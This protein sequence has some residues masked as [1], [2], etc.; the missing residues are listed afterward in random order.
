[1]ASPAP[2]RVVTLDDVE[3]AWSCTGMAQEDALRR[4]RTLLS[5]E[6]HLTSQG[7]QGKA[8]EVFDCLGTR[9]CLKALL[10]LNAAE[11]ER[12]NVRQAMAGKLLA[13]DGEWRCHLVVNGLAGFPALLC[14]GAYAGGPVILMEWVDGVPLSRFMTQNMFAAVD[15]A[16][17]GASVALSLAEARHRDPLFV[18][19]DVSPRNIMLRQDRLGL[20][21]QMAAHLF[22][23][24]VIDFG[25]SV[26]GGVRDGD[27]S[28]GLRVWR[29]ATPAYAPPEML[30]HQD[31]GQASERM[32]GAVD[33]YE[34]CS[35][36]AEMWSRSRPFS[37]DTQSLEAWREV[38][39]T[40][41][42]H[43]LNGTNAAE[44]R[45][46]SLLRQG[47]SP[48]PAAR[49]TIETAAREL[50]ACCDQKIP[51]LAARVASL[52]QA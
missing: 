20:G 3:L 38:K 49:P 4:C 42:P 52:R 13:F 10:P 33:V 47:L 45:L 43:V 9:L 44:R 16:S 8:I 14:R 22:D 5:L 31:G 27:A 7:G 15:C 17:L 35:V 39:L 32:S 24:C 29:N 1:M 6:P 21:Q 2:L 37:S 51:G 40:K 50:L 46:S 34:L 11:R 18:H 41:E 12:P 30:G 23:P 28:G 19:R 25:S 26:C 48:D 36:I